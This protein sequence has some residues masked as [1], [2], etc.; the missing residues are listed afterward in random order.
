VRALLHGLFDS[1]E[2]DPAI[3][4]AHDRI[5]HDQGTPALHARLAAVDPD[6]AAHI[7]INDRIR[8]SRA[9]E[10]FEQTGA[11]VSH[12]RRTHAFGDQRYDALLIG[13]RLDPDG[14]RQRIDRRVDQ[15][16]A[17]GW[18]DEVRRLCRAGY[19]H[20]HPM[21]ALGYRQL[22]ACLAGGL[23]L[24]Q[25]VGETKRETWRF[26]RRQRNWFAHEPGI[27]WVDESTLLDPHLVQ[28]LLQRK[29]D[30][31]TTGGSTHARI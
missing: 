21:G 8:I 11:P 18:L 6:A 28:E 4:A 13:L 1:P 16:M 29:C 31:G 15:M 9:L 2:A 23:D 12:L 5:A 25:A 3:R 22:A 19:T 30:G 26:S 27:R 14:L 17:A 10:V 24:D 7:N 20:T